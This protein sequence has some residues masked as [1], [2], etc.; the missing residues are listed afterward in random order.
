MK[1]MKKGKKRNFVVIYGYG[2]SG[3]GSVID[4]LKEVK[5]S[6]IYVS[7][8]D[9]FGLRDIGGLLELEHAL[10]DEW[11]LCKVS[12]AIERFIKLCKRST[13]PTRSLFSTYGL[14]YDKWFSKRFMDYTEAF[15]D[16]LTDFR[17]Y[18]Y[19]H[20]YLMSHGYWKG[21]YSRAAHILDKLNMPILPPVTDRPYFS[22]PTREQYFSAARDYIDRIYDSHPECKYLALDHHPL[23]IQ[24]AHRLQDYYGPNTKMIVVDRDPRNIYCS[25][26]EYRVKIGV[27]MAKT[28]NIEQYAMYHKALRKV[29]PDSPNILYLRLEDM[30]LNYEE[31]KKKV[32][33]FIGIDP[34]DHEKPKQF[35]DPAVSI[36]NLDIWRKYENKFPARVFDRI[37]EMLGED[38]FDLDVNLSVNK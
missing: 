18:S 1:Y 22:Q 31:S 10:L 17:Y 6:T 16:E 3:S 2:Y 11:D 8:A 7:D 21:L 34:K 19:E 36:K 37:K 32:F 15:I 12:E 33:D 24:Q 13:H 25:L 4:L 14:D 27:E 23:P 38:C 29:H 28:H 20:A 30:V 5:D 9:Y 35:F 26:I